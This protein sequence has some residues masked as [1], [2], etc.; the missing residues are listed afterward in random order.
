ML[1]VINNINNITIHRF[2]LKSFKI[3]GCM[4]FMDIE[5]EDDFSSL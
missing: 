4:Y 3:S 5:T 2:K 1:H